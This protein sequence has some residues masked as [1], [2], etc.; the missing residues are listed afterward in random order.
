MHLQVSIYRY[1]ST[2]VWIYSY[3]RIGMHVYTCTYRYASIDMYRQRYASTGMYPCIFACAPQSRSSWSNC[4]C[5][6]SIHTC[7]QTTTGATRPWVPYTTAHH[8]FFLDISFYKW[9]V[10]DIS[11]IKQ[12]YFR[13]IIYKTKG[14]EL[15]FFCLARLQRFR[16]P[17]H[18]TCIGFSAYSCIGFSAYFV[19]QRYG[20]KRIFAF[21][22]VTPIQS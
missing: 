11:F 5:A 9:Y 19:L 8:I 3:A 12:L 20:K 22:Y 7:H 2:Q 21:F 13:Y 1:A 15:C 16:A 4:G 6:H 18:I 14:C 10:L 17:L